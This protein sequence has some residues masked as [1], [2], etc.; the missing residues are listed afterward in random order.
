M[1]NVLHCA[2]GT[3]L[4]FHSAACRVSASLS[5]KSEHMSRVQGCGSGSEICVYN[6]LQI[7]IKDKHFL[8]LKWFSGRCFSGL[9]CPDDVKVPKIKITK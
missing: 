4:C 8:Y 1:L 2:S 7:Y 3:H 5:A 6:V 9:S